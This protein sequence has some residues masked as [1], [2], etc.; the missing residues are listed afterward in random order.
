VRGAARFGE[1]RH[2]ALKGVRMH[3]GKARQR[4]A[5]AR[6]ARRG[7]GADLNRIDHAAIERDAHSI[8]PAFGQKRCFKPQARHATPHAPRIDRATSLV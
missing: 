4:R 2:A 7:R 1:P 5:I 8:G 3:V 6:F